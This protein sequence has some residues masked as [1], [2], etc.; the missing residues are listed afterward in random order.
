VTALPPLPH[1]SP[2]EESVQPSEPP[3]PVPPPAPPAAPTP[4]SFPLGWILQNAA[5]PIQW[6]SYVEV[7]RLAT[8]DDDQFHA[9]PY[10]YEPALMLSFTQSPDGT[11]NRSMLAVPS[12]RDGA[13]RGAGT[14]NAVRRLVEYGWDR[15]SPPLVHAR[16]V[17]FRLLAEDEDPTYLYELAPKGGAAK[18]PEASHAARVMI[19]EAAAAALA[20]AGYEDDPRLRGAAR[21]IVDRIVAFLRSPLARKPWIR[22]GNKQALSP[23]AAPPSI[24]AL[25]MLAHMPLFRSEHHEV[26]EYLYQYLSQPL[27]RQVSA[28]LFGSKIVPQPHLVLGDMLATRNVVDAD[29]P[30]ALVWLELMARLNFLR[31]NEGWSRLFERLLDDRDRAGVW[32]PHKGMAMPRSTNPLAWYAFPLETTHA[33]EDRWTDVTFRL[34]LIARLSGRPIELI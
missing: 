9:L 29:V 11:W 8:P 7:A 12:G 15:E 10:G 20:Q 28:Q 34:G 5:P 25:T 3:L 21:R 24:Y 18:E 16:R 6:R 22:V 31:Q 23:D 33:G 2:L 32:H 27:P 26:V 14:I 30:F 19:R 1:L 13:V 17:L 4:V